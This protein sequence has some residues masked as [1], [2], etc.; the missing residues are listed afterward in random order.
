MTLLDRFR[1]HSPDK[2]PDWSVRLAYVEEIPLDQREAI[3]AIARQDADARVRRA[4]VGKL[5]DPSV[6]AVIAEE[7]ADVGVRADA[8]AMLRDIAL[9]AFEGVG[10]V[11]SAAA[12]DAIADQKLILQVA[13]SA[14]RDAIALRAL[15]KLADVHALG[16]VARHGAS[17]AAR[18]AAFDRL[19]E[20]ADVNELVDVAMNSEFK[21]TAVAA[22][23]TVADRGTLEL[24]AARGKNRSAV[25]RARAFIRDEDERAAQEAELARQAR[26]EALRATSDRP[27][28]AIV[29]PPVQAAAP[30][31]DPSPAD[32]VASA[33]AEPPPA[34]EGRSGEGVETVEVDEDRLREL[35]R[36]RLRARELA[37]EAAAAAEDPDLASARRR[38]ALARREW[39]DLEPG[40]AGVDPEVLARIEAASAR[41]DARDAES[42][43]ADARARR[44]ALARLLNLVTRAEALPA[45]SDLSL[46]TAERALRD[47]RAAASAIPALPTKADADSMVQR[48]KAVQ[49]QLTAKVQELREAD[50]WQRWANAGIQEQLCVRMERL[51]EV[52]DPEAVAREVR[53]L[54]QQWRQAADVPKAKA[55]ALWRRFKA[56]HDVAWARCEQ[57]FAEQAQVRAENL[58]R[59]N[60]MC[61]RAE[62]LAESTNWIQT[63][64]EI[65]QLQAAWKTIGPVSRGR[66]KAIWERFRT[67]CDRFF[68]RRHE[69]LARRKA[70]WAAN[71]A[72]KEALCVRAEA[73]ATSSDWEPALAEIKQLQA[74]WKT[75][76]PVKK[77]RSEAIWQRFRTACDGFFTRYGQRHDVVRAERIAAREAIC[78]ELEAL[79]AAE[80]GGPEALPVLLRSIRSRWQQEVAARGVDPDR[81]RA[82]DERFSAALAQVQ[83]RRAPLLAGT[84]FDLDA[85]R[86][87]MES[88]VRRVEDLAASLGSPAAGS[89]S[90]P[91][92]SPARLAT[93]L[94][95]A[96]AANTI[97]GKVD[98]TARFRAAAEDMRQAQAAWARLGVV[99]DAARRPLADR[100]QRACRRIAERTAPAVRPREAGRSAPAA[101]SARPGPGR[102]RPH[103]GGD[104][105]RPSP[106]G[107]RESQN[108]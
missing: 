98:E 65:K 86:R 77:T 45:L 82:L 96:L 52:T 87:Q 35:E 91:A 22:V 69:D 47:V 29:P 106:A 5:L 13:R 7:D 79:A 9:E 32:R 1:S 80:D 37:D 39:K 53:E 84:E 25:K 76:G 11:E 19:R 3:A 90:D 28:A 63:A 66:E 42:R 95:E 64:D 38:L 75:I 58:A 61:E 62:A 12:A 57:H 31:S 36:R 104:A 107:E 33:D 30:V 60:A 54:Q 56:A 6:L 14:A 68:T 8:L 51:A 72:R 34:A 23:E 46:K 21:D 4:A 103:G 41:L 10:E 24:I 40:S 88:L 71:L 55:D 100:F 102:P 50:E 105:Q 15:S 27:E 43:E 74:E 89:A 48:L 99:P 16:A 92:V 59:K 85:N 93:M 49:A 94:K 18:R 44:E 83:A 17:E 78:G 101:A 70:G 73:L 97:G 20:T 108:H 67:A 2:H 26:L 81:A